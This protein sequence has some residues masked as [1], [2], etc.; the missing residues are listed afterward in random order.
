MTIAAIVCIAKL[1]NKYIEEFVKYHIK[2]GFQYIFIYDN[3]NLPTYEKQLNLYSQNV[4][5]IHFPGRFMQYKALDHFTKSF[6]LTGGITH[7]MHIDVDEFIVLKKHNN[8]IDFINEYIKSPSNNLL[9]GGIAIN[10][11]FFGSSGHKIETDEPVTQR[12][13]KCSFFG[14]QHIKTLFNVRLF[15]KYNTCHD[16]ITNNKYYK[17]KTTDNRVI[18]GPFNDRP[19]TSIIQLNHYKC[20]TLPEFLKIRTRGRADAKNDVIENVQESFEIYDINE[21]YDLTAQKFYFDAVIS[22]NI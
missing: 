7:A 4:K 15:K 5:V 13:T 6:M 8:I 20:K 3:E 11:K 17:I 10:W 19:D 12:F 2:L 21:M 14:D 22:R 18:V 16:I 1:E 9:C